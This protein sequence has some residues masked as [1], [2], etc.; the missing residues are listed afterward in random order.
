MSCRNFQLSVYRQPY[1][2]V[3]QVIV[4]VAVSVAATMERLEAIGSTLSQITMYDIKTMYNQVKLRFMSISAYL[5]LTSSSPIQ[6]KNVV[7]NVSEME[8]KVREATNDEPW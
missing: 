5:I 6:A 1:L 2:N 4:T 7:L 8:A 3:Q